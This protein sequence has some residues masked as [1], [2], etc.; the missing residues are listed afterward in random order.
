MARAL[1]MD[2]PES[3]ADR[4]IDLRRTMDSYKASTLLDFER[5][6]PLV[7]FRPTVVCMRA[8]S[9]SRELVDAP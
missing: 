4:Q 8:K 2:T 5:G 9:R 7:Y 3:W 6:L 1:G